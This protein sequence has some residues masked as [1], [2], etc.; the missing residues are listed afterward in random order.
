M[1]GFIQQE[2][3]DLDKNTRGLSSTDIKKNSNSTNAKKDIRSAETNKKDGD[4]R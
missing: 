1:G 4:G 2:M 3:E